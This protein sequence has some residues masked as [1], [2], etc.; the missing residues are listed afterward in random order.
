MIFCTDCLDD[1]DT[2]P[3]LHHQLLDHTRGYPCLG[4][5]SESGSREIKNDEF[6]T[7]IGEGEAKRLKGLLK[8]M[9]LAT[10][11]WHQD[12]PE[13]LILLH[14]LAC[15][16]NVWRDACP[17]LKEDFDLFDSRSTPSWTKSD[18]GFFQAL[19]MYSHELWTRPGRYHVEGRVL[20]SPIIG[21]SMGAPDGP[22][23]CS[24]ETGMG[25]GA[26]FN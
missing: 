1:S 6:K 13:K 19:P 21:H 18:K 4:S 25:G 3:P 14:G 26:H 22:G 11:H 9:E 24:T 10:L 20:S 5:I 23:P 7:P 15:N 8:T 17:A 12:H 2:Q 16:R